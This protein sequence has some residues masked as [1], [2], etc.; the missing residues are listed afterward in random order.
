MYYSDDDDVTTLEEKRVDKYRSIEQI[1]SNNQHRITD[2]KLY[3]NNSVN[4]RISSLNSERKILDQMPRDTRL[5]NRKGSPLGMTI[6]V[7][8]SNYN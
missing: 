8:N 1:K 4:S 7:C 3:D 2:I 5:H 6:E